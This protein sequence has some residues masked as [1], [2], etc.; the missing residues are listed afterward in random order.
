MAGLVLQKREE[1]L[2]HGRRDTQISQ[3]GC[4]ESGRVDL[5]EAL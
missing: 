5:K 2:S 4:K 1:K 3:R